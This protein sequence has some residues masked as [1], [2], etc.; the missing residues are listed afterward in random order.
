MILGQL[1]QVV[2]PDP[3]INLDNNEFKDHEACLFMPVYNKGTGLYAGLT[4]KLAHVT[5]RGDA[6]ERFYPYR[7]DKEK[8]TL[9]YCVNKKP[10]PNIFHCTS[11]KQH[12]AFFT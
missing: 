11:F 4:K 9:L 6:N 3:Q 1:M 8:S 12:H 2:N 7:F 10:L 5:L